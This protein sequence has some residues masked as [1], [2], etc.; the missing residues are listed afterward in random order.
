MVAN[1]IHDKWTVEEYLAFEEESEIRH[2]FVDGQIV[3]MAG[4]KKP[5]AQVNGAIYYLLYGQTLDRDCLVFQG[6]MRTQVSENI[7][8]YPDIAVVCGQDHYTDETENSLTNPTVIIE[9]LSPST[10]HKDRGQKFADY[11]TI[12]TLQEY[13]LFS[14]D[15]VQV[16]YYVRKSEKTWEF[17]EIT[18]PD[19]VLE[20]KSIG[21]TLAL[22]DVYR[23]IDLNQEDDSQ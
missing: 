9:V 8:Y 21:C 11:R 6:D 20:L 1:P 4:A 2:E 12:P 22:R 14:Q 15:R 19:A 17:G 10:E 7:Y 18:D 16:E 3:A 13:W 5:H 23:R